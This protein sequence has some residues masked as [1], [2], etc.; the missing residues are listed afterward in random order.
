MS[1]CSSAQFR[2]HSLAGTRASSSHSR[3][4]EEG[5]RHPLL[6]FLMN[7]PWKQ[8]SVSTPSI[9]TAHQHHDSHHSTNEGAESSV[10]VVAT[11]LQPHLYYNSVPVTMTTTVN[12]I[13]DNLVLKY[14]VVAED[15]DPN[16]FYLME[17]N[18]LLG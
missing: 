15:K 7:R 6:K 8:R 4:R 9:E 1:S 5:T 14:A 10:R 2:R 12:D 17:V 16:S 11:V 18:C 13:I 3:G